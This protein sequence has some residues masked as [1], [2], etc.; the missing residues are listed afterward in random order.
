MALPL[1]RAQRIALSVLVAGTLG[2]GTLAGCSGTST[3][4][5]SSP[6][7][8]SNPAVEAKLD[9]FGLKGKSVV[10]I[11]NALDRSKEDNEASLLGSVRQNELLLTDGKEQI[12]MPMPA[13]KTYLSIA[14]YVDQ[15]HE[16]F[17]HNLGT[18][19]GEQVGQ[20]FTV[21]ITDESGKQVLKETVTTYDNGFVGFW[22][23][24]NIK[25]TLTVEGIGKK[26]SIPLST[27][28]EDPTCITTL[29]LS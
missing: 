29:K 1:A 8:A 11:I 9:R 23:P 27:G 14:P 4:T 16:C 18:C 19:Q 24:R 10:E 12:S 13:D 25:G 20:E 7:A 15:T 17:N 22:V 6:A 28:A 21:T 2:L 3:P 5:A 26:G